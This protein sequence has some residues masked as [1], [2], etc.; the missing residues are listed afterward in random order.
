MAI[1]YIKTKAGEVY[2]LTATTDVAF[3]HRSTNTRFPTEA[4]YSVTDHSTVENTT[5]SMGGV[6]T[7]VLL[8]NKSSP[9]KD[10]KTYIEGLRA[11]QIARTPFTVFLD[12]KLKPFNNCLFT[13][14]SYDKSALEG[15]SGWRVKL[16]IEQIRIVN[17]AKAS[18]VQI[19][20]ETSDESGGENAS[21]DNKD[22]TA[23][24]KDEGS[25]PTTTVA[26]KAGKGIGELIDEGFKLYNSFFGG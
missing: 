21:G 2:E 15:L 26:V 1:F 17:K 11:L 16:G 20:G 9:T 3:S 12:D 5:I 10:I 8:L 25:R 13:E 19:Q 4:G 23:T 24:K 6:I 18:L 14:L 7:K 22:K